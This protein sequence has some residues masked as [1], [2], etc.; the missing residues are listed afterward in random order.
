MS[1]FLAEMHPLVPPRAPRTREDTFP[2]I[3][4]TLV[5]KLLFALMTPFA[6]LGAYDLLRGFY[7]AEAG[8]L[9]AGDAALA[10]YILLGL[11]LWLA[12]LGVT[13]LPGGA[14]IATQFVWGSH[15]FFNLLAIPFW[16]FWPPLP[17]QALGFQGLGALAYLAIFPVL[18]ISSTC[19]FLSVSNPQ[20][21]P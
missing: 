3:I 8:Q 4:Q 2:R 6:L 1:A 15:I 14:R 7:F 12:L 21:H 10:G 19:L 5:S 9:S 20:K 13:D 16:M 17:N 11:L 18:A